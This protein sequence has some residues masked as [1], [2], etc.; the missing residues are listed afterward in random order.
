MPFCCFEAFLG[1][2]TEN[3]FFVKNVTI[4]E[5]ST[6]K[7]RSLFLFPCLNRSNSEKY[8]DLFKQLFLIKPVKGDKYY[9]KKFFSTNWA[10]YCLTMPFCCFERFWEKFMDNFLFKHKIDYL[11]N[12]HRNTQKV[13]FSYHVLKWE[14]PEEN[15]DMFKQLFLIK[16]LKGDK[17]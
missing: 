1:K 5:T 10:T 12:E 7:L 4:S 17:Y 8:L 13:C 15:L 2:F 16:P 9:Q 14:I 6:E 11:R 3:F